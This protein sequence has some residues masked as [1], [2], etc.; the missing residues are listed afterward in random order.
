MKAENLG[1]LQKS[2]KSMVDRSARLLNQDDDVNS[3]VGRRKTLQTVASFVGGVVILQVKNRAAFAEEDK[4]FTFYYT[5]KTPVVPGAKPREK[6]DVKGTK[7][8]PSFLRSISQCKVS[9]FLGLFL[10]QSVSAKCI[11]SLTSSYLF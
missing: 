7:K 11:N 9:I 4:P 3:V 5:G 1:V 10:G 6:S 2:K 8:D